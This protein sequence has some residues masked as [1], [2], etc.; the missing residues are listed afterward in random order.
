MIFIR[1][2]DCT[3]LRYINLSIHGLRKEAMPTL[4]GISVNNNR[5]DLMVQRVVQYLRRQ[6][7]FS[8]SSIRESA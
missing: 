6:H 4:T 5:V 7:G 3:G 2:F 8:G 1:V